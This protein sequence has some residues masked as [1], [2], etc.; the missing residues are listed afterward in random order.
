[1][2][3]GLT[4]DKQK[5]KGFYM[6]SE[7]KDRLNELEIYKN[8]TFEFN[9]GWTD[10]IYELG[11]DIT[12]LC[13]LTNCELPMIQQI[14]EKFGTLRFYYNTL[15]SQYP[16]I[17]EKSISA[18]VRQAES[19]SKRI[20]AYCGKNAELRVSTGFWFTACDEHK[21]DSITLDEYEELN[22][23]R[24]LEKENKEKNDQKIQ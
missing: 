10:L 21:K 9:D 22:L 12:E 15:N 2:V 13:E 6:I 3:N 11:K 5:F 17:V 20:C 18:L 14:K 16:K 1:M 19:K 23:I 24:R 7:N 4:L 8:I